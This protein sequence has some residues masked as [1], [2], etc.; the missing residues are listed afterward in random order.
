VVRWRRGGAGAT[1][2][3][4]PVVEEPR[5]FAFLGF[6][7]APHDT[8]VFPWRRG[9]DALGSAADEP[10]AT[11]PVLVRPVAAD[12]GLLLVRVVLGVIA[13]FDGAHA[14]FDLPSGHGAADTFATL[15]AG[16]GFS[17]VTPLVT[18]Y[19]WA[20]LVAGVLVGLGVFASFA[21]S[22]LLAV[23]VVAVG[24]SLPAVGAAL[25]VGPIEGPLFGLVLAAVVVL[26]GP[27]RIS[28]DADRAW[29]RAQTPVG[30][31]CMIIGLATGLTVLFAFR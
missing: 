22:A 26:V 3:T 24:V 7:G 13:L 19:G 4:G 25:A 29:Y 6:E 9:D 8:A 10:V 2:R 17:P 30:V 16:Y 14:L 18:A 11:R 15:V 21:A 31:T 27:G 28:G 5:D 23:G 20:Q 12:V 1:E